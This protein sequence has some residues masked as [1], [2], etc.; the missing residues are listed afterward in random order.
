LGK[1]IY[2]AKNGDAE[3]ANH[4][5]FLSFSKQYGLESF[6][7]HQ[8]QIQNQ[9]QRQTGIDTPSDARAERSLAVSAIAQACAGPNSGPNSR[10][11]VD[12]IENCAVRTLSTVNRSIHGVFTEHGFVKCSS[13]LCCG[14]AWSSA[15]L[16][17]NDFT[18]RS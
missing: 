9:Q 15:L 5:P 14:G 1:S 6:R 8:K 2:G 18:F 17:Q 10:H 11:D 7:L 3:L 16:Y 13:V 12:I 4:D